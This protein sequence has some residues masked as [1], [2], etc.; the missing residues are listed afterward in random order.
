MTIDYVL[1]EPSLVAELVSRFSTQDLSAL[2][3]TCRIARDGVITGLEIELTD[4]SIKNRHWVLEHPQFQQ[5][6]APRTDID[7][8]NFALQQLLRLREVRKWSR[9]TARKWPELQAFLSRPGVAA[10]LGRVIPNADANEEEIH[11]FL[12]SIKEL[13]L[14]F[15]DLQTIPPSIELLFNLRKLNLSFNQLTTIPS[16]IKNLGKLQSLSLTGNR[17]TEIPD[18]IASLSALEMLSFAGN[19]LRA[20]PNWI[21]NLANLQTLF[22]NHNPLTTVPT[23]IGR[24]TLNP[25]Q[26]YRRTNN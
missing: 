17:L 26:L 15:L 4:W 24:L 5:E 18:E 22:A 1:E 6:S 11:N 19:R 20:I 13:D 7:I 3:R 10:K 8:E 2:A 23:T 12:L 25:G 14:S 9:D 16:T 21:T